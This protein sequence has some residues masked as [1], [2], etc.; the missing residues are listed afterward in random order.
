MP[1]RN[2]KNARKPIT[3]APVRVNQSHVKPITVARRNIHEEIAGIVIPIGGDNNVRAISKRTAIVDSRISILR[4]YNCV[5]P[6]QLMT[7]LMYLYD[8]IC[9][10]ISFYHEIGMATA[11][12]ADIIPTIVRA[13]PW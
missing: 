9:C 1:Y 6:N 4:V 3:R 5:T 11:P 13:A 8:V 2:V 10:H 12:D 7:S